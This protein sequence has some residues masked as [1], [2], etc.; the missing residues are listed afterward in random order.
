MADEFLAMK[1]ISK[2]FA[3]VQA[4]NA[5][6]FSISRGEIHCLVGENGSGKSTLI[7]IISGVEQPDDGS[8]ISIEGEHIESFQ[9]IDTI[10]KG[11]EV[12]Y[13]DLSLF[14]NVTVAENIAISQIIEKGSQLFNWKEARRISEEAMQR[15][16]VRLP[17]AENV[18]S[19]SVA[20]QQLVAICR[21][22]TSDVRLL[23]LDE[24]TSS[25][26]RKEV[27][28][29]FSVITDLK[30]KEIATL[31][32]SHKLNEVFQI[33]ERVTVLRDG[34]R[35]GTF[36]REELD[37]EELTLLM[38]GKK[39]EYTPFTYTGQAQQED[40]L[41]EVK[42]LSKERNFKDISFRLHPGEIL[43][44]TGLLGS[45][46]TELAL[47]LFGMNKPDSGEIYV[48]G[49]RASIDSVQ[50][51][52]N[53]GIGYLPENRL[54]QGLVMEQSIGKNI[55]VTIID[56]L[57][58]AFNLIDRQRVHE[59]QKKGVSDLNIRIPSI[60][61]SVSTLSGG[62]QQRVVLAKWIATAP[63]ILI[64]DGP[65]IGIDVA[66]KR[67][68]HDII[69]GLAQRGIG[70]III[71]DEVPEV[72]PNCNRILLMRKGR[73]VGEFESSHTS[74]DELQQLVNAG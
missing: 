74:E 45:G 10:R 34:Q 12:I 20:D 17:L 47:S 39:I 29:L 50:D 65:T 16:G 24:P 31:F 5:V 71:S 61:S 35:I 3:G 22:L 13:Q 54:V 9:S 41:L 7:K 14:P 38:T 52:I 15:I 18:G 36:N 46:R 68:I 25:L 49:K 69:R 4:L 32:V 19:L 70:I 73:I 42:N 59:S 56:R 51:A 6:D 8:Q 21:A 72:V 23:I 37:N 62:N 30:K 57:R 44:I 67:S 26:T 53:L 43:G 48:K 11:I 40:I 64:L 1:N 33:A 28:S 63:R 2:R 66:A 55:V 60:E 58:R 27:D